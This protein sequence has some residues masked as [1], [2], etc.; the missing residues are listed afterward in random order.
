M[1]PTPTD[2]V[3]VFDSITMQHL[4]STP[5]LRAIMSEKNR[6]QKWLDFEAALAASVT[7]HAT[8]PATGDAADGAAPDGAADGAAT[9][10]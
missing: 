10:A 1:T 4:W 6:L 9:T 2:S 3:S 7:S 5:E 8:L